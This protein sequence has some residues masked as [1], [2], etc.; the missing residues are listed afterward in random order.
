MKTV[1]LY[2]KKNLHIER[3]ER[4][5]APHGPNDAIIRIQTC[6]VC[7]TD[8][9]F[10]TQWDEA[11]MPLGHEL[12][13]EVIEVGS[14]VTTVKPGDRVVVEDCTLCGTC[15]DC[16]GGRPDLCQ[17]MFGLDGQSGMGQ[18]MRVRHNNLVP[19]TDIPYAH[20]CLAEPLAVCLNSVLQAD[21]PLGGSVAVFGSGPLG[22]MTARV[23]L[24]KGAGSVILVGGRGTSPR[25]R[26]R[27]AAAEKLGIEH[28][29]D[30]STEDAVEKLKM[31]HP[32][33]VDRV[34]VSSPPED[35]TPAIATVRYGGKIVFYGLHFGGRNRIEIDINELVFR[36]IS[37]EPF[38][39]EQ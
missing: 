17:N 8:L 39:A 19:F 35:V 36:K 6:G 28:V 14:E 1:G 10:V 20:A 9:N 38:F 21:V 32:R 37:L 4:T 25:S 33:G 2:G 3:R 5:L 30:R 26:A 23:A 34:I 27:L 12:A 29:I 15:V 31:L 18:Y 16:K 13:A 22:L 24:L 7:G 11:P